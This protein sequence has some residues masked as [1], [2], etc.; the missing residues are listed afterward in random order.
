MIFQRLKLRNFGVYAGEHEIELAPKRKGSPVI[1]IGGLNGRGKTTLLDAIQLLFF[2]K[3][4]K[5]STRGKSAYDKFLLDSMTRSVDPSEGSSLEL[6]FNEGYSST[7]QSFWIKRSWI[8][9]NGKLN[10][11]FE[12]WKGGEKDGFLSNHWLENVDRFLPFGLAD[13]F[14]FDGEKIESLAEENTAKVI[15]ESAINTLFG[16]DL[17]GQ[18]ESDLQDLEKR[19]SKGKSA[20]AKNDELEKLRKELEIAV[21]RQKELSV[22]KGALQIDLDE[23]ETDCRETD[24]KYR[25]QGGEMAEKRQSVE[26]QLSE[27][28]KRRGLLLDEIRNIAS[29]AGPLMIVEKDIARLRGQALL[30]QKVETQNMLLKELGDRDKKIIK[31]LKKAEIDEGARLILE[32]LFES[33]IEQRK[34][35]KTEQVYLD[36]EKSDLEKI[37][38]YSDK[39]FEELRRNVSKLMR[40]LDETR[41]ELKEI[42]ESLLATP[43]EE[44]VEGLREALMKAESNHLKLRAAMSTLEEE[45][46]R[47]KREAKELTNQ[48]T[49]E[50][51]KAFNE[52]LTEEEF[53]RK[54]LYAKKTRETL[55]K[56]REKIITSKIGKVESLILKSFQRLL[57]KKN[58]VNKI[59]ISKVDFSISLYDKKEKKLQLSRMSA[60]ERQLL[61][62]SILWGLAQASNRKIPNIIDTPLGRLDGSHRDN[63]VRNYFTQASDQVIILSTDEEIDENLHSVLGKAV[64]R[65]YELVYSD[66]SQSTKIREGYLFN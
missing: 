39:F 24:E 58:L 18:L 40:D 25:L 1:L 12:V 55:E 45:E 44:S 57:Q 42:E 16:V 22:K 48:I 59:S 31:S 23:A 27:T 50:E 28:Q 30:E 34:K 17:I 53:K 52:R 26:R 36:L 43:E 4:N 8:R 21:G 37:E 9:T 41:D 19:L 62:V 66:E 38:N 35:A 47:A 13:L 6:E 15:L 11:T 49:N 20:P 29:Q 65:Q 14:F 3:L 46:A 60:G 10:E 56:Y 33:D 51:N 2:G 61:A 64:S 54:I 5:C 63:I 32:T 7:E